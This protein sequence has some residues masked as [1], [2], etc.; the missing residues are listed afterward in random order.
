MRLPKSCR[1]LLKFYPL[2][3]LLDP[4]STQ[5]TTRAVRSVYTGPRQPGPWS[6]CYCFHYNY[7]VFLPEARCMHLQT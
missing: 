1:Q 3:N 5:S 4:R 6:M 2:L 7:T